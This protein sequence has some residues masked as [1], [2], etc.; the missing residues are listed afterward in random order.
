MVYSLKYRRPS[1]RDSRD[2]I[3]LGSKQKP[4]NESISSNSEQISNGIPS[5]LSFDRIVSGGTC[6][7]RLPVHTVWS[8]RSGICGTNKKLLHEISCTDILDF[9]LID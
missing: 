2:S 6:P 1:Y 3:V 8:S 5:A 9:I 4:I 7:V